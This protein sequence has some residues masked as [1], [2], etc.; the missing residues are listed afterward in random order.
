MKIVI[1]GEV[2]KIFWEIREAKSQR[3][4]TRNRKK[5]AKW[6]PKAMKYVSR[7]ILKRRRTQNS[8]TDSYVTVSWDSWVW[9]IWNSIN[10]YYPLVKQH[11]SLS[12]SSSSY[13][14][15]QKLNASSFN[16]KRDRLP[17]QYDW[18]SS[19][20]KLFWEGWIWKSGVW[21]VDWSQFEEEILLL[22]YAEKLLSCCFIGLIRSASRRSWVLKWASR[23]LQSE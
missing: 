19:S 3:N 22:A 21:F 2:T 23:E 10:Y 13:P 15:M 17:R 14:Q 20:I 11:S 7:R 5:I 16:V 18:E 6:F 12:W 1:N 8:G 4:K 9:E